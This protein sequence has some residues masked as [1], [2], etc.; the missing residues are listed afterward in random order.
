MNEHRDETQDEAPAKVDP[1]DKA[2]AH[3][4]HVESLLTEHYPEFKL[5]QRM[6]FHC[7]LASAWAQLAQGIA[8][9]QSMSIAQARFEMEKVEQARRKMDARKL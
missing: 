3:L 1:R 5:T 7:Q 2:T 6:F 9:V 4:L 8:A